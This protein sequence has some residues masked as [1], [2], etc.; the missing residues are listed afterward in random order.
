MKFYRFQGRET[1]DKQSYC[2]FLVDIWFELGG[3]NKESNWDEL[4]KEIQSELLEELDEKWGMSC[5][6]TKML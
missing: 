4:N 5:L 2:E 6:I 1:L 3:N